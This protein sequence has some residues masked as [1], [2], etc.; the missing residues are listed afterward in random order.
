MRSIPSLLLVAAALWMAGCNTATEGPPA[1]AGGDAGEHAHEE[2]GQADHDHGDHDHLDHDHMGHDHAKPDPAEIEAALA[3]LSPEDRSLAEKQAI[4]P[5][6]DEPLGSMGQPIKVD[7][8]GKA[9]FI[10]CKG[11]EETVREEP[12]RYL[13]KIGSQP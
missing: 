9:L 3:Q 13:A 4:C 12:E 8:N 1:A 6:S 7:L 2:R 10:C 11:C 5:V